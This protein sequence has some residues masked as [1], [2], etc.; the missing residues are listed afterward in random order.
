MA[1]SKK[2]YELLAKAIS[3]ARFDTKRAMVADFQ[4]GIDTVVMWVDIILSSSN[5]RFNSETFYAK[6]GGWPKQEQMDTIL[7]AIKS[8]KEVA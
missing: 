5:E 1:M 8:Q 6:C 2:D 3:N 7:E 4:A